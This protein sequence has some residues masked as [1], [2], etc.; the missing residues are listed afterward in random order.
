M[1]LRRQQ[2]PSGLAA[3]GALEGWPTSASTE[4]TGMG[5]RVSAIELS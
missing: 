1:R 4:D 5:E 3:P 2:I